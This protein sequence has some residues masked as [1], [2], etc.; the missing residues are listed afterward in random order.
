LNISKTFMMTAS[1]CSSFLPFLLFFSYSTLSAYYFFSQA[2]SLRSVCQIPVCA[3]R[4]SLAPLKNPKGKH[5]SV[6]NTMSI[7]REH[8][9]CIYIFLSAVYES[10]WSLS[11]TD[12]TTL[13]FNQFALNGIRKGFA[14]DSVVMLFRCKRV[15]K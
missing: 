15:C 5:F 2:F 11:H 1:Q 12:R 9:R 3:G 13:F 4:G 8:Y 14:D 7:N 6:S 10:S